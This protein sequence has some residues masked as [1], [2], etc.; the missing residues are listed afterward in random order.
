MNIL[1]VNKKEEK[2]ISG[3]FNGGTSQY[4]ELVRQGKY[5]ANSYIGEWRSEFSGLL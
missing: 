4:M 1:A 3:S 2:Y 5:I